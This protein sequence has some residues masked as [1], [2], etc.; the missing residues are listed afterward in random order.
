[1]DLP[2]V[3]ELLHQDPASSNHLLD[4]SCLT[5]GMA[6]FIQGG[7]RRKGGFP[8]GNIGNDPLRF[9]KNP[10]VENDG[11]KS[12]RQKAVPEILNLPAFRIQ[13]SENQDCPLW[14]FRNGALLMRNR[15]FI[16]RRGM[17]IAMEEKFTPFAIGDYR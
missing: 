8:G 17:M 9:S 2:P 10:G 13:G 15:G 11:L 5:G 1:M 16:H 12:A 4:G 14:V 7:P 6:N 3:M